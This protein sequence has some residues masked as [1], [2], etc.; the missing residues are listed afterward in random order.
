MSELRSEYLGRLTIEVGQS[1]MVGAVPRGRMRVDVFGGG[2]FEGPR[3]KARILSGGA[4]V[5]VERND[6]ALQPDVRLTLETDDGELVFVSYRGVRHGSSEAMAAIARGEIPE[7]SSYY[8]R[9][10]PFFETAAAKYDWLN[11]IVAVGVGRRTPT[12]AIYEVFEIL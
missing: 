11:R 5:L 9:N 8:L 6:K 10:A 12:Q 7:P 4:D 1:H 3:I 2:S